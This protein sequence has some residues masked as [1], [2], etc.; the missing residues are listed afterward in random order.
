MAGDRGLLHPELPA[1]AM[2]DAAAELAATPTAEH[3]CSNRTCEIGLQQTTGAPY[4]SFVLLLE[5]LTQSTGA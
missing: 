1:S 5:R 2:R 3:V 4:A